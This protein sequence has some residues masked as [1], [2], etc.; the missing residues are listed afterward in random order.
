MTEL[1]PKSL[2]RRQFLTSLPRDL[3]KGVRAVSNH[4]LLA[5]PFLSEKRTSEADTIDKV[6]RIDVSRCHAW[7]GTSCQLCY[8]ACPLRETAIRMEDQKPIIIAAGCDGCNMCDVA[9][10]EILTA[11]KYEYIF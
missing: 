5:I 4:G 10:R 7:V 2:K 6:A 3:L 11:L 1:G 8:L 9:C